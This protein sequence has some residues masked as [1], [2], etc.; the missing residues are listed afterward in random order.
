MRALQ[1]RKNNKRAAKKYEIKS[2]ASEAAE[3]KELQQQR[4]IIYNFFL[5]L[6]LFLNM[7]DKISLVKKVIS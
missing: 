6:I 1:N 3:A 2:A 4:E 7:K 5:H